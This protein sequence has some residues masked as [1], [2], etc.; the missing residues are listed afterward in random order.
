MQFVEGRSGI[1]YSRYRPRVS[2][3]SYITASLSESVNQCRTV[4]SY[5]YRHYYI[6]FLL[7]NIL[8]IRLV[9]GTMATLANHGVAATLKINLSGNKAF[10]IAYA[11][12]NLFTPS[13]IYIRGRLGVGVLQYKGRLT[14]K[15]FWFLLHPF[16]T[17][18]I[19]YP[20]PLYPTSPSS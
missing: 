20:C 2:I 3:G 17:T 11:V 6:F 9:P 7:V 15:Q 12:A 4:Y 13:A 19:S 1:L 16:P 8:L 10:V 18:C 14:R 5:H